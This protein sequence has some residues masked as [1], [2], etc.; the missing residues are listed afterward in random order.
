MTAVW[1]LKLADLE[2]SIY[3]ITLKETVTN[4]FTYTNTSL[5]CTHVGKVYE[6][7]GGGVFTSTGLL[8]LLVDKTTKDNVNHEY[9][10]V[11]A[12]LFTK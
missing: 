6:T 5:N 3:Y 4:Y 7:V 12:K 1:T 9:A 10:F 8:T 2:Q 11:A